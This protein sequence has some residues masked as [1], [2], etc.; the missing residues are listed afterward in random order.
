MNEKEDTV[1]FSVGRLRELPVS[2]DE[3]NDPHVLF[4]RDRLSTVQFPLGQQTKI[5]LL[6]LWMVVRADGPPPLMVPVVKLV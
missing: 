1:G 3:V 2:L 5:L 6:R 4:R